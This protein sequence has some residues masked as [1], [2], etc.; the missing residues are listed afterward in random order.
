M[1]Q[2]VDLQ[3][4]PQAEEIYMIAG[5]RQWADA[6]NISSGLPEY[7]IQLTNA[8]K[9]GDVTPNGYYIF[10]VPGT[11]H[12]LRPV[13]QLEDGY[14]RALE[15]KRNEIYYAGDEKK[16]LVIFLGDEPHLNVEQYGEAFFEIT[17]RLNVKRTAAV[18][19]VYGALPYD[20]ER[21][22]S[23]VYSLKSMKSG[24][25]NY[26]VRFSNY[27][28]GATIGAFLLDQAE[29]KEIEFLAMY[30]FAPAYDFS[31][32]RSLQPQGLRIENDFKAW[33]DILRRLRSMMNLEL[34]LADLEEQ[35]LELVTMMDAKIDEMAAEMP[36]LE[37]RTYF[38]Q[39]GE[40]YEERA[41]F[42]LGSVWEEELR[43]LFDDE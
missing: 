23:V 36:Q 43:D 24:L 13:V 31:D 40:Q 32:E 14:R 12:L 16:G 22:I 35:S 7:L 17:Q 21:D 37:I 10:Q 11:H 26:A 1:T 18:G 20:K 4:I 39:L 34:D 19:G 28:G 30:A 6:G 29:A 42:E 33:F 27:E 5:W 9:I 25:E 38:D 15:K 8:R 41:F 3:E 2:L